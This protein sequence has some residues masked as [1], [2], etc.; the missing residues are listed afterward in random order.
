VKQKLIPIVSVIGYRERIER[1]IFQFRV[2][3]I[4][5]IIGV[6]MLYYIGEVV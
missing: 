6:L 5:V 1:E 2:A 4:A 3:I